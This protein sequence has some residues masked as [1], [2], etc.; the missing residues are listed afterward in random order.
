MDPRLGGF[1]F[2][3][4]F[5]MISASRCRDRLSEASAANMDRG[6]RRLKNDWSKQIVVVDMLGI[7]VVYSTAADTEPGSGGEGDN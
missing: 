2:L 7:R 5:Q 1:F 6:G 4:D 3:R